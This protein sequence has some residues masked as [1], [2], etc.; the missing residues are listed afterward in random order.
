MRTL[1]FQLLTFA[2]GRLFSEGRLVQLPVGD[3]RCV[4]TKA[5][6]RSHDCQPPGGTA[7]SPGPQTTALILQRS[8]CRRKTWDLEMGW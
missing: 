4:Q 6:P 5:K 2:R 1:F 8:G 7:L 3:V